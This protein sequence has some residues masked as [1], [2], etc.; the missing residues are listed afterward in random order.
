LMQNVRCDPWN[1]V[2]AAVSSRS[3]LDG[4]RGK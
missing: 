4:E 3:N 1:F 2:R